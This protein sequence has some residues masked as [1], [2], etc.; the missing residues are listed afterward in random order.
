MIRQRGF[1]LLEIS[2]AMIIMSA[3]AVVAARSAYTKLDS[4]M[5]E[6]TAAEVWAIGEYAQ[7]WVQQNGTWPDETSDCADAIAIMDPSGTFIPTRSTWGGVSSYDYATYCDATD[8]LSFSITA[9]LDDNWAPAL[10]NMLAVTQMA[11]GLTDTT[12]TTMPLPGSMAALQTVLHRTLDPTHSEYNQMETD[13]DMNINNIVNVNAMEVT[14]IRDRVDP[15]FVIE[16][17][18][19]SHLNEIKAGTAEFGNDTNGFSYDGTTVAADFLSSG[20]VSAGPGSDNGSID[21]NDIYLRSVEEY[22]SARLPNWVEKASYIARNGDVVPMPICP[23]AG[24]SP[25]APSPKIK[26]RPA[27]NHVQEFRSYFATRLYATDLGDDTWQVHVEAKIGTAVAQTVVYE[28]D[29]ATGTAVCKSGCSAVPHD[30]SVD[31][32]VDYGVAIADVYC[33]YPPIP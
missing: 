27:V 11:S 7:R 17:H 25:Q 14:I 31:P 9:K 5:T 19:E 28:T 15:R 6:H 26:L 32:V 23:T 22:L 29:P 4:N 20:S 1:T 8:P 13:L 12:V 3:L 21:V 33:Y 2:I 30:R 10:T 24:S 18:L 16:P